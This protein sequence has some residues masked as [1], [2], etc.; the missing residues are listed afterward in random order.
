MSSKPTP[1]HVSR[2]KMKTLIHKDACNPV[3]IAIPLT[4]A[5]TWKQPKYP[6]TD[7]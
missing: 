2:K 5:K 3:F 1:E 7:D 6:S 4:I